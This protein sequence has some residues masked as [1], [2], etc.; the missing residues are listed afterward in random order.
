MT[1]LHIKEKTGIC[2]TV[3]VSLVNNSFIQ[4]LLC[5][6]STAVQ[7]GD[8][9]RL[10]ALSPDTRVTPRYTLQMCLCFLSLSSHGKTRPGHKTEGNSPVV[11]Q[12]TQNKLK[13]TEIKS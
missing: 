6:S 1:T 3:H 13:S 9:L 5:R 11:A 4:V 8:P 7:E 2:V 12:F 10:S